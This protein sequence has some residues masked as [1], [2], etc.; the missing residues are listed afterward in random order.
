[1]SRRRPLED[2]RR[3][4]RC[5]RAV[6]ASRSAES[7]LG[8]DC[9]ADPSTFLVSVAAMSKN[10]LTNATMTMEFLN[11][12]DVTESV[13]DHMVSVELSCSSKTESTTTTSTTPKLRA[14]T[15]TGEGIVAQNHRREQES[16]GGCLYPNPNSIVLNLTEPF[17]RRAKV[18]I[19]L[20]KV[21][22]SEVSGPIEDIIDEQRKLYERFDGWS[23]GINDQALVA[24]TND[25]KTCFAAFQAVD[26]Q[27]PFG[28]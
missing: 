18:V 21:V 13:Q 23:D 11:H 14:R 12:R 1:M 25:T 27:N 16:T 8:F 5:L 3:G 6:G 9:S 2:R 22:N 7:P 10:L 19:D 26:C 20:A 17:M 4:L 28:M 24:K 15:S